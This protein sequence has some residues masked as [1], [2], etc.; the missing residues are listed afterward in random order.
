MGALM[1]KLL[2][3][4]HDNEQVPD[5]GKPK[6][7]KRVRDDAEK[8]R[9]LVSIFVFSGVVILL[10]YAIGE[11]GP[12]YPLRSWFR[13]FAGFLLLGA[14]GF[15]FGSLI[16]F[17]FGIP[18]SLQGRGAPASQS[19]PAPSPPAGSASTG[20]ITSNGSDDSASAEK[21][22]RPP[23]ASNT[24]LEEISDW[25]TKI[26]VGV[27]LINLKALPGY[28]KN[29]AAYFANLSLCPAGCAPIPESSVLAILFYFSICGF[30][31]A[32][33]LTRLELP[34]AFSRAD[35]RAGLEIRVSS[36]SRE[37][38]DIR[39][40]NLSLGRE[41]ASLRANILT[42]Q[43]TNLINQ[44][45]EPPLK[46]TPGSEA[47]LNEALRI[48]TEALTHD[49]TFAVA[50]VE[51]GRAQ[52][53]LSGLKGD[54]QFLIQ[55]LESIEKACKLDDKN[56]SAFYNSACYKAL[57][58]K[59]IDEITKDLFIAISLN[60]AVRVNACKDDDLAWARETGGEKFNAA[61]NC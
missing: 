2:E 27:G 56:Y 20:S 35:R 60:P 1:A 49:E 58:K 39:R 47:Q 53:R 8:A 57:L 55:A 31:L 6:S 19:D 44:A 61:L 28:L 15:A 3:A 21:P 24:N 32:Y 37:T 38:E 26:I 59:P 9:D 22:W 10:V 46:D 11:A 12:V 54:K 34:A 18:R 30:F 14:A 50:Y 13:L 4:K 45:D 23:Y 43:A 29:L 7:D 36:L 33:L 51:R 5:K 42:K 25:L 52:K 17:L 16:G 48:I 40:E 41:S